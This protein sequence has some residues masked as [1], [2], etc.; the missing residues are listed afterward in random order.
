M[1][2]WSSGSRNA[3]FDAKRDN[4]LPTTMGGMFSVGVGSESHGFQRMATAASRDS[5]VRASRRG[6]LVTITSFLLVLALCAVVFDAM[7]SDGASRY[8]SVM[9]SLSDASAHCDDPLGRRQLWIGPTVIGRGM[10]VDHSAP[11]RTGY[12]PQAELRF[13]VVG[14]WGRDGMCCQRDVAAEMANTAVNFT[15]SF[16]ANVGDSFYP[17]GLKS[18]VDG[19]IERSWRD[20][21]LNPYDSLRKIPWKSITGN[22]DHMGSIDALLELGKNDPLWHFPSPYYFEEV[23][24]GDILLCFLDTSPLYYNENELNELEMLDGSPRSSFERKML[25]ENREKE[26]NKQLSALKAR[27]SSSLAKVKLVFGHHPLFSSAENALLESEDMKRINS[28]LAG[29]LSE[30]NVLA[31]FSGH[32]HTMEHTMSGGVH[33]FVVG[34]GSKVNPIQMRQSGSVF[35]LGRQG[36]M[37]VAL[38]DTTLH[39]QFIDLTGHVVH[40]ASIDANRSILAPPQ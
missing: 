22:H 10:C 32:E 2:Q 14:D 40:A 39:A 33:Y 17:V 4:L 36:F 31:Y 20:V 18:S 15:P 30:H 37:A 28:E 19:Q 12:Y 6:L 29:V 21:Y 13:F 11:S 23:N 8:S 24:N 16:I 5:S 1:F 7:R 27:L 34:S 3:L 38:E 25:R 9:A 26:R 35:A